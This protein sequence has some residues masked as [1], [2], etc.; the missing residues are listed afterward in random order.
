MRKITIS[1]LFLLMAGLLV[2]SVSAFDYEDTITHSSSE[3][4]EHAAGGQVWAGAW[5][6]DDLY[7]EDIEAFTGLYMITALTPTASHMTVPESSQQCYF[8]AEIGADTIG[9]GTYHTWRSGSNHYLYITFDSWDIGS[10]TGTQTVSLVKTG[11]SGV[12]ATGYDYS[13]YKLTSTYPKVWLGESTNKMFYGNATFYYTNTWKQHYS[14]GQDGSKYEIFVN[15]TVNDKLY[16]SYVVLEDA[17]LTLENSGLSGTND[18]F[19]ESFNP[20]I[21]LSL[22]GSATG[23][24]NFTFYE[25]AGSSNN[26]TLT[27]YVKR[28]DTGALLDSSNVVIVDTILGTTVVNETLTGGYGQYSLPMTEGFNPAHYGVSVTASGYTQRVPSIFFDLKTGRTLVIEMEPTGEPPAEETNVYAQFYV[29]TPAGAP[30]GSALVQTNNSAK[31]TNGQGFAQFEVA[32]NTTYSYSVTKNGYASASGSYT[33]DTTS[34]EIV[35]VTLVPG[36]VP[37]PTLEPGATPTPDTRTNT[38]KADSAINIIYNNVEGITALA[39]LCVFVGLMRLMS[40]R[41]R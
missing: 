33:T 27:I 38:E 23:W 20:P 41:R 5:A 7:F 13:K 3:Y 16:P 14:I 34:P 11:G 28:S 36:T 19:K 25:D 29:L 4:V 1:L 26:A 21:D 22:K 40:G 9:S 35:R 31:F 32:K 24:Y 18:I 12:Y 39:C 37:T 2:G 10:Y 17:L 8:D 15:R 6:I 30:V